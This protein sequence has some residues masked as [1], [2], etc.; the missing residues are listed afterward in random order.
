M[1]ER[2]GYSVEEASNGLIGK[3]YY[4]MNYLGIDLIILDLLMPVMDGEITFNHLIE[5]NPDA[6]VI[7]TTGF[8][9]N[10]TA[11][12]ILDK[13]AT[14]LLEKP[15]SMETLSNCLDKFLD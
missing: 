10:E 9:Q 11:Q 6:K 8:G 14:D 3:N 12:R 7:L 13:G 2:L 1:L 15:Y 4:K 5:I